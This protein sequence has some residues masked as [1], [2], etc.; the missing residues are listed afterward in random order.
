MHR[1]ALLSGLA[2][3]MLIAPRR[4]RAEDIHVSSYGALMYGVPYTIGISKGYFRDAGADVTGVLAARGGGTTVRNILA[5]GLPYGEVSLAAAVAASAAGLDIRIV[6]TGV[7]TAAD[8]AWVTMPDSAIHSISDLV[9]RKVAIT[10]PKSISEMLVIMSL[11]AAGIEPARVQRVALGGVGPGLTALEKGAVQAAPIIDPIWSARRDRYRILF[12]AKDLLKPMTQSV[13][14]ATTDFIRDQ[15]GVL[16]GIIAGRKRG[17]DFLYAQPAQAAAIISDS[18]DNLP[19]GV[20]E[21]AIA[22]LVP[23][24]YWS[25]GGFDVAAMNEMIRGLK[26]IGQLDADP[27][28]GKLIDASFLPDGVKRGV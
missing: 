26:L 14:I 7:R 28:W 20:A 4:G 19:R 15:P 9:G 6:N 22:D 21:H 27:D 11:A 24:Q 1:R 2:G 10:E 13:S 3:L 25:D 18:Y 17:V 23:L 16:R 12:T 8:F 5:G